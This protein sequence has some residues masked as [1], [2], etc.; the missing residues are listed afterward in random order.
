LRQNCQQERGKHA[1][2]D[3]HAQEAKFSDYDGGEDVV[4]SELGVVA[5]EDPGRNRCSKTGDDHPRN[6][7]PLWMRTRVTL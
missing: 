1:R 6:K 4:P 5:M 7:L 2:V 3:T